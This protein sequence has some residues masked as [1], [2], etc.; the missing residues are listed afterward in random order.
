MRKPIY[1]KNLFHNLTLDSYAFIST[2]RYLII[3]SA[4]ITIAFVFKFDQAYWVPLSAN[5]VMIGG[6][7][8]KGMERASLRFLGTIVGVILLSIILAFHPNIVIAIIILGL[9]ALIGETLV[10][11]NYGFAMTFITIQVILLNGIA[12]QDISLSIALPRIT[13]VFAGVVIAAIGLLIFGRNAASTIINNTIAN[14][15]R[16]ESK[17]FFKLFSKENYQFSEEEKKNISLELSIKINNMHNMYDSAIEELFNDKKKIRHY[18]S[19]IYLLDELSFLLER[20]IH[21]ENRETFDEQ[22]ISKYLFLFE[23]LAYTL[24]TKQPIKIK[25]DLPILPVYRNIR[26]VLLKLQNHHLE[27]EVAN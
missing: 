18:Y 8:L 22:L 4:A 1:S 16:T 6:T 20:A 19:S 5:T 27:K 11:A 21:L 2:L 12:S 24:E 3:M 9:S 26:I 13:D 25:T 15:V 14:V 10:A 7:T 23:D 17:L